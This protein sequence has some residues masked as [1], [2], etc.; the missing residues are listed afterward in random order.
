M[1]TAK[2]FNPSDDEVINWCVRPK[3]FVSKQTLTQPVP[4][5]SDE[6]EDVWRGR[7]LREGKVKFIS[8][9]GHDVEVSSMVAVTYYN[10]LRLLLEEQPDFPLFL[11]LLA[12]CHFLLN[13]IHGAHLLVKT[14]QKQ[15]SLK[16]KSDSE[17]DKTIAYL[18]KAAE[19]DAAEID[20][21]AEEGVITIPYKRPGDWIYSSEPSDLVELQIR[22][23]KLQQYANGSEQFARFAC[24]STNEL[25][26]VF[27]LEG[28]SEK[29]LARCGFYANAIDG[30]SRS[31]RER[32]PDMVLRIL[33]NT[34]RCYT[35][36]VS[37]MKDPSILTA[38]FI[39]EAHGILLEGD[40]LEVDKLTGIA[41]IVPLGRFRAT[42]CYASHAN[43][44]GY[45][46]LFC[47]VAQ[48]E[49][50]MEWLIDTM[51]QIIISQDD[52]DPYRAAAWIHFAFVRIHP[53]ADGNGRMARMIASIPLLRAQLPPIYVSKESKTRYFAALKHADDDDDIDELARFLQD[54][55]FAAI[56]NLIEYNGDQDASINMVPTEATA[57]SA[58]SEAP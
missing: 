47:P 58:D 17:L 37:T 2:E 40:N 49:K 3:F 26:G 53:F 27:L 28:D 56:E 39:K 36:I 13:D 18:A 15:L 6:C 24:V 57:S 38:E 51:Q 42:P 55:A 21:A 14:A 54:E 16:G 29:K 41:H 5:L 50:D 52:F 12:E 45:E 11:I 46:I 31:S 30:I 48:L 19:F 33:K 44:E 22:W 34:Q 35:R 32:Q 7:I 4:R 23:A 20:E 43:T 10:R 8:D 25:E 9:F 1:S